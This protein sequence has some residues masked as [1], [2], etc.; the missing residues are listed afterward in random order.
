MAL[1]ERDRPQ[2][3]EERRKATQQMRDREE[4]QERQWKRAADK[5]AEMLKTATPSHH[6]Y[7]M[8]KGLTE[9][10]VVLVLPD[11][12]MFVPMRSLG[13]N[14]LVGAQTIRWLT[15]ERRWEK[16]FISGMRAKGAVFRFG[17]PTAAETIV[18]EGWA[19]GAS[20]RDAV[21]M[22][23]LDMSVLVAFSAGNIMAVAD[24]VKGRRAFVFADND[25]SQAGEKSARATGL[26]WTMAPD[27]GDDAND[28]AIKAGKRALAALV[29][30][31]R[32]KKP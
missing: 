30:A 14:D 17:K 11:S 12:S 10:E 25:E 8:L 29:L 9:R 1:R 15:D 23:K 21:A 22:L 32:K 20:L 19:T 7:P 28:Y 31:L 3:A 26:P 13:E 4:T 2:S 16:K 5:A 24:R 6:G 18:C 27:V